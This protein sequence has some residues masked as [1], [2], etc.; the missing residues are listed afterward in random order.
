MFSN[1]NFRSWRAFWYLLSKFEQ[2]DILSVSHLQ[3]RMDNHWALH[4]KRLNNKPFDYEKFIFSFFM[5]S[6]GR[7]C[8][9]ERREAVCN[10]LRQFRIIDN[11]VFLALYS[12]DHIWRWGCVKKL[13]TY[14]EICQ[15]GYLFRIMSVRN[16]FMICFL[17]E[18]EA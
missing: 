4:M 13:I 16:D 3:K 11:S 10:E 1:I 7:W 18:T 6:L 5:L 15:T 14:L 17:S 2:S 9:G 8:K 12:F